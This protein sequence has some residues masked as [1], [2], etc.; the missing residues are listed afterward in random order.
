MA[1]REERRA[2]GQLDNWTTGQLGKENIPLVSTYHLCVFV[3]GKTTL[4]VDVGQA[5][6]SQT[7]CSLS[8]PISTFPVYT[9]ISETGLHWSA[10]LTNRTCIPEDAGSIPG[11]DQW[12]KDPA[13]P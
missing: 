8:S 5:L 2:A 4:K 6:G 1:A 3:W 12:V 11:L 10:Q 7:I 9:D 13:L